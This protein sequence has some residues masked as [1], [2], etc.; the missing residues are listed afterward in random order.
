M[1]VSTGCGSNPPIAAISNPVIIPSTHP[2]TIA[3]RKKAFQ[4]EGEGSLS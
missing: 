3:E 2:L 4:T 1:A